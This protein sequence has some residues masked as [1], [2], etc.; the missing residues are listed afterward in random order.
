MDSTVPTRPDEPLE[1]TMALS[2]YRPIR[3][4]GEYALWLAQTAGANGVYIIRKK[5]RKGAKPV[6]LYVGESHTHRLRETLQRHFQGWTGR[7]AGPT[8]DAKKTEVAIEIFLLGDEAID[9][10]NALIRRFH[11]IHNVV[12]PDVEDD[13]GNKPRKRKSRTDEAYDELMS[14]FDAVTL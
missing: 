6:I 9:R 4:R 5:V 1:M 7:T 13:P 3:G 11:P 8:F 10:Q 12:V 14:F 2:N